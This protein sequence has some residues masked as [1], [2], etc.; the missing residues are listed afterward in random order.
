MT[1]P[2]ERAEA[3]IVWLTNRGISLTDQQRELFGNDAAEMFAADR[4]ELLAPDVAT[5]EGDGESL[6]QIWRKWLDS[7]QRASPKTCMQSPRRAAPIER[8][9]VNGSR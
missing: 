1:T 3:L 5:G 4:R 6:C 2:R 8:S 9:R 7:K